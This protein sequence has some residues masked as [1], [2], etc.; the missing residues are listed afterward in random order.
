MYGRHKACARS[1]FFNE[2]ERCAH[3]IER[4]NLQDAGITQV[5]DSLILI[6][7]Q[8][9]L[10]HGAGLG[11]ILRKYVTLADVVGPLPTCQSWLVECDMTD[12]VERVEILADLIGEGLQGKAFAF[13]LVDNGLLAVCGTPAFEELVQACKALLQCL[14]GEVATS[15]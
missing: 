7:L 12:E 8:D 10:K 4:W 2:L 15:P 14:L 13:E 6:L 5:N 1:E 9:C 3:R 11:T